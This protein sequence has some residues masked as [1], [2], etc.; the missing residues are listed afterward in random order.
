[1]RISAS[2]NPWLLYE[3]ISLAA[4]NTSG[5]LYR[6]FR[7][8]A[9]PEASLYPYPAI[10]GNLV[11]QIGLLGHL[12]SCS[13]IGSWGIG[14]SGASI[15]SARPIGFSFQDFADMIVSVTVVTS[16]SIAST[17]GLA[18]L[19]SLNPNTPPGICSSSARTV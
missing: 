6:L 3:G 14:G 19:A 10:E 2:V 18:F 5:T 15:V 4:P 1:M 9:L 13:S 11:V 17:I 16:I 8:S 7:T 12:P